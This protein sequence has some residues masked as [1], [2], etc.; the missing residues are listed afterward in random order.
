MSW[1]GQDQEEDA[2]RLLFWQPQKVSSR[3]AQV[4]PGVNHFSENKLS[5]RSDDVIF[6]ATDAS[7]ASEGEVEK[8]LR[9]TDRV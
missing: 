2:L 6:Q 9:A 8:Q 5:A 3:C 7:E 4:H 1:L